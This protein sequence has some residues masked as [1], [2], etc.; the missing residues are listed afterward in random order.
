MIRRSPQ[1]IL[2]AHK[3]D[4]QRRELYVEG[5]RDRLFFSWLLGREKDPNAAVVEIAMVESLEAAEGG[6]RGRLLAFAEWM[7][8]SEAQLRCFA[9]ADWDR[10]LGRGTPANVWLTDKRDLEG[11]TLREECLEKVLRLGMATERLD[12]RALLAAVL[13]AARE[14]GIMRVL[15]VRQNLR[16]P[17]QK[18]DL[19]RHVVATG[20]AVS[21][22]PS[23]LRALVQNAG[24]GL[25]RLVGIQ[26]DMVDLA[27]ELA[28]VPNDQL[29]H[30]K[31]AFCMLEGVFAE[32]GAKRGEGSRMMWTSFE[33]VYMDNGSALSAAYQYLGPP[34]RD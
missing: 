28:E 6:E 18:T 20:G 17:F 15:S 5:S 12:A 30:G 4:R 24:I 7:V 14:V 10:L 1:A 25:G 26:A 3:M 31:D 29:V 34:D 9:D 22:R 8:R 23:Y 32:H 21:V 16:L 27:T 13:R 11:Y 19:W 33:R 2:A